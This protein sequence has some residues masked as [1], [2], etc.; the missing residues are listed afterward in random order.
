MPPDKPNTN[1]QQVS[2]SEVDERFSALLSNANAIR[3]IA[4]AVQG[5]LG[6]KG[7]NCMLVDRFGDVTITNDGS[8]ILDKIEVNHPAAKM[9]IHTAKA[10]ETEVGDGT[11]TATLLAG[12]LI[13]EAVNHAAKGVPVTKIIEGMREGVARAIEAVRASSRPLS[14]LDDPLLRQAALIAGRGHD[15]IAALVVQAARLVGAEALLDPAFKL[16]EWVVAKEGAEGEAVTGLV[17]AKERLNRQMPRERRNVRVLVVDDALEPEEI[18]D[19][20][21]GTDAGFAKYLEL[22]EQFRQALQNVI[23]L[24]VGLVAVDGPVGDLAE[25][26]LTDAGVMVIR[27][28]SRR[29]LSRLIEHTGARALKRAGLA[30][31]PGQLKR[32]LGR[33]RHVIEDERLGHLRITGGAGKPMATIVVGAATSEVKDERQRIAE[34]AASAVQQAIRGGVVAGGGA[35]EMAAVAAVQRLRR[36]TRGMAAYGVDCVIEALKRPLIQIV[37]NAGFNP[38]EKIGDLTVAAAQRQDGHLAIDCDTGEVA[39]MLDLG[40]VDP[41]PV[42]VYAL[43]AAGEIAE[44]ILS[45]DTIIKKRDQDGGSPAAQR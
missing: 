44:A 17:I 32:L 4:S 14:G 13:G 19:D 10:Q 45:I 35:A 15:D 28:V 39:D 1:L 40:V 41:T 3:A 31:E 20:A 42:K 25:E 21:L 12:A 36:R 8:A 2:A 29:D 24:G 22:K 9:L 23:D 11:T 37:A 33:A 30:R 34:D 5:T 7:L 16:A 6:P 18:H 26:M 43:R 27:R 38:L